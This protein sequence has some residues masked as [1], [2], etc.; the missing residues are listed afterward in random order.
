MS[1]P[2]SPIVIGQRY[3]LR[4]VVGRG[5]Y[6]SVYR[7]FDREAQA[8]VA[9]K[10]LTAGLR[11][12]HLYE[13]LLREKEAM[14]A[15]AGT[16]AVTAIDLCRAP[17]GALCLVMEWLDGVDLERY[18]GKLE[19]A[20]RRLSP[21]KLLRIL[22]PVVETLKRA[23]QLGI[24]HRDIKPANVFLLSPPR[25]GVKLLD[26][27]LSRTQSSAPLTAAGIV[28]GSPSYIA[29]EVWGGNSSLVDHRADLYSL[30]VI[31]FR[32]LSGQIPFPTE[33]LAEKLALVT[34]APRP[35]L[36]AL[37]PD[38]PP[39]MDEWV[40]QALAVDP[41]YRFNTAQ[42][43]LTALVLSL[44]DYQG[45]SSV[46]S[47]PPLSRA[48]WQPAGVQA[49]GTEPPRVSQI[50]LLGDS[51]IKLLPDA[52]DPEKKADAGAL[53]PAQAPPEAPAVPR[54]AGS[55]DGKKRHKGK[56]PRGRTRS[57]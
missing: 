32:A 11:D 25:E 19:Q 16:N 37:R 3:E 55:E 14:N 1:S 30:A 43:L 4:E 18:L 41:C 13:R 5:G 36:C 10:V 54:D 57:T 29:P 33:S 8:P 52:E 26:F 49:S 31:V 27:G 46:E 9:V 6:G 56:R 23:H 15:L 47:W 7:A 34:K 42:G 40:T 38:L 22:G 45:T 12:P 48:P 24:V 35:S 28:M 44:E 39:D 53:A 20:G 2:E 50:P 51:A 21:E 17:N